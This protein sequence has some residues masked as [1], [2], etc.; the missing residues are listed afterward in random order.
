MTEEIWKYVPGFEKIYKI[1]S[2]GRLKSVKRTVR[3]SSGGTKILKSKIIKG[4]VN[5]LGYTRFCL[6]KNGKEVHYFAHRLVL[7]TFVG[8]CPP[9]KEARHLDGNPSNNSLT[10]LKWGTHKKNMHDKF[11]HNTQQHGET[12]N[13]CKITEKQALTIMRHSDKYTII[14]RGEIK[15]YCEK[16]NYSRYIVSDIIRHKSWL[17]LRK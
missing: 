13:L 5:S 11:R 8:P 16:Y 12:H 4:T 3:H 1:S 10:N 9:N 15:K 7:L 6:R 14:P 2:F 17:H